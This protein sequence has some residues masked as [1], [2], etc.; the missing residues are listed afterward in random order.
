[1]LEAYTLQV[2]PSELRQQA[3]PKI[4]ACVAP[5]GTL[6]LIARG[7]DLH[8]SPGDSPWPL[9]RAELEVFGDYQLEESAFEDYM[10]DE[11]PPVRRFMVTYQ[12]M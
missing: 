6:L 10:D 1:V 9:T 2:L 3:I 4:A 11:N 8:E 7:R 12:R 5:G